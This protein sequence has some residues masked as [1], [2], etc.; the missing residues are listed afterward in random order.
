MVIHADK[1]FL[2]DHRILNKISICGSWLLMETGGVREKVWGKLPFI[3]CN[4]GGSWLPPSGVVIV[5]PATTYTISRAK[6]F[7]KLHSKV[8][9]LKYPY[10][11]TSLSSY[12]K[13]KYQ[14][15]FLYLGRKDL[16][17]SLSPPTRYCTLYVWGKGSKICSFF[18][19]GG[20]FPSPFSTW[21]NILPP[22]RQK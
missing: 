15:F 17:C 8:F 19:G 3:P 22:Y 11:C 2:F 20:Y 9:S 16:L 13:I 21:P 6:I 1:S 7:A 12:V 4:V 14:L 10:S 5:I 18:S